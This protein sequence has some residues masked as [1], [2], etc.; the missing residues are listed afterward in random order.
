[1]ENSSLVER[2]QKLADSERTLT[3][4]LAAAAAAAADS[5]VRAHRHSFSHTSTHSHAQAQKA[6]AHAYVQT[7][8]PFHRH[9]PTRTQVRKQARKHT[10]HAR[11]SKLSELA[12][13]EH[14]LTARLATAAADDNH[15]YIQ[16]LHTDTL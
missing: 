15:T 12:D 7:N 8:L 3:A 9:T 16:T 5:H 6:H 2:A 14:A 1:M 10:M 13:S 11:I 4:R